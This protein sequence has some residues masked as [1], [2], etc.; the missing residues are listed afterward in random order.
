MSPG[1]PGHPAL[2]VE[3]AGPRLTLTMNDPASRNAQTPSLWAEL[4]QQARTIDPD[5]RVV[6]LRGSG[7]SFSAGLHRG[8]FAPGGIPGEPSLADL[9]GLSDAAMDE[10]IARFQEAFTCWRDL[11]AVTIALVQGHAVGAGFQLALGADLRLV[12]EDVAFSMRETSLGLVPDLGGT[13]RL[14]E[15]VG[16]PRA[17]E[18]CATGRSVG[19]AEAVGLGLATA[20]VPPAE[21]AATADDLVEALLAPPAEGLRELKAL[22]AAALAGSAADQLVRERAAQARM[23]RALAARQ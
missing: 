22:L 3:R 7:P 11:S 10:Q 13:R 9:A 12:S 2:L 20:A 18:I 17:L 5:V 4:A 23:L 8:M 15:L 6:V 14:V 16:Y 19:A 21:L 1:A